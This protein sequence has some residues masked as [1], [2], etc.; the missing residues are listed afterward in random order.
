MC[1]IFG[2]VGGAV[3][4]ELI[5]T[6]NHLLRHRGPDG[7]GSARFDEGAFT[8][9]RLAIID[10]TSGGHQPMTSGDGAVSVTFNGEIYNY[11]ELRLELEPHY[12]FRTASDTEVIL[13]AYQRWGDACLERLRGM[14][15]FGLWDRRRRRLLCATDRLSIKPLLYVVERDRFLFASEVKPLA[16]AGV[17][18]R[19]NRCRVYDY[20]RRGLVDHTDET[21][22]DGVRQLRP[23]TYLVK[24]ANGV[25]VRRYWDLEE[26]D[27]EPWREPASLEAV[28]AILQEAV[29][30]APARGCRAGAQPQLWS[31]FQPAAGPDPASRPTVLHRLFSRHA[32]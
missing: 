2:V 19:P 1:G 8:H 32:V 3:T 15:A 24:D 28:E 17:P 5:D 27:E 23:G 31:R 20:L 6:A 10:L 29:G 26:A 14:F 18:L 9:C 25:A 4:P 22:F 7:R 30:A 12:A 16:A 13:A 11:C 21:L